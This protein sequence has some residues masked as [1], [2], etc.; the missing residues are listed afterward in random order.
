MSFKFINTTLAGVVLCVSCIFNSANAGLIDTANDSYIDTR[1]NLE[2][3]DFGI[4]N[5]HSYNYVASQLGSG[6][7]YEGWQLATS[8][9]VLDLWTHIFADID[10]KYYKDLN[11][12][13]PGQFFMLDG[14]SEAGSVIRD[15]VPTVMGFNYEGN[16]GTNE[17][18][19]QAQGMFEGDSGLA[20]VEFLYFTDLDPLNLTE[21]HDS[22]AFNDSFN[23]DFVA[24]TPLI[25]RSTLLVKVKVPEP[26]TF[27]IFALGVI[28]L[29]SRRFKKQ[30]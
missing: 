11:A 17:Q 15:A 29:A 6:G 22:V 21:K 8:A 1:T 2:W 3:M 28:G 16:I 23:L 27:A 9:Q 25:D 12:F 18:F 14:G 7:V 20:H 19:R 26:S 4:N 10:A 5:I 30:S 13:G 24:N